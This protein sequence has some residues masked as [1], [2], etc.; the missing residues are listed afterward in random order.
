[1]NIYKGVRNIHYAPYSSS[2]NTFEK[3][4]YKISLIQGGTGMVDFFS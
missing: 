3:F 4:F 1:L 2:P